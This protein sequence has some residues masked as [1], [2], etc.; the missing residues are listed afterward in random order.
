MKVSSISFAVMERVYE[1]KGKNKG[2]VVH[3]LN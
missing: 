1:V 2:R 3:L